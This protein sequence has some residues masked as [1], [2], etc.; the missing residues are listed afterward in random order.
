MSLSIRWKVTLATLLAVAC[1]LV[2]AG[3]MAIQSLEQQETAQLSEVLEAR[4]K[5]IEYGLQPLF[6]SPELP[7]TQARLQETARTLG[8]RALARV[9][10]IALVPLRF[11]MDS[12]TAGKAARGKSFPDS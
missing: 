7:P 3:I 5:L 8:N 4:T 6:S 2:V 10:V 1:G 11:E 9:T 12:V